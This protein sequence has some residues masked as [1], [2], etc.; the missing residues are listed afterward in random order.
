MNRY[1]VEASLPPFL[2]VLCNF[3][4]PSL[5]LR[6]IPEGMESAAGLFVSFTVKTYK[7]VHFPFHRSMAVYVR[8]PATRTDIWPAWARRF[9]DELGQ[10][11]Q[12]IL[13][14]QI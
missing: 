6:P 2:T 12:H 11:M 13:V 10:V 4:Q 8:A 1:G 9:K 5:S 7:K 14:S 3:L